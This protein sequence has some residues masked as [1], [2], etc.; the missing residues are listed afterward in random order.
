MVAV[1]IML[2]SGF[3]NELIGC[4]QAKVQTIVLPTME[5]KTQ[6]N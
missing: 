2:T 5:V 6:C 4:P 3:Q 1:L